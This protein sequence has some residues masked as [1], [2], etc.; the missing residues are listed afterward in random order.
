MKKALIVSVLLSSVAALGFSQTAFA[1]RNTATWV[2]AV[3]G[4]RN[5]GND[6]EYVITVTGN[7]NVPSSTENTFGSVTGITITIEG[8]GTLSLSGNGDILNIGNGQTIIARNITLRGRSTANPYSVV[9]VIGGTFHMEGK[10]SVTGN[11]GAG[12]VWVDQAGTFTMKDNASV[13]GNSRSSSEGG[14][15]VTVNNGTFTMKDRASVSGNT[16]DHGGGVY[17]REG[18]FTMQGG[19]ISGN[20]SSSSSYAR[21][22]GV[23]I[24]TRGIFTMESGTISG[25]TASQGGG[26][27]VSEGT[28]TMEGGTISGN[29]TYPYR[30]SGGGGVYMSSGVF[31][32]KDGLISGNTAIDGGGVF[33]DSTFNTGTFTMEG[34]TISGNTSLSPSGGGGGVYMIGRWG[35]FTMENGT[36]SG[37]TAS[38]GGGVCATYDSSYRQS[39]TFT[40]KDGTISGNTASNSGGGVYGKLRMQGGAISGNTVSNGGG[41]VYV[42]E[43]FTKTG[44]TIY[45]DDAEQKL[46]NT[47]VS[48]MGHAVYEDRNKRWRNAGAGR[49]MNP[50]SYGFW[51]SEDA[52]ISG[53]GFIGTWKRSN[54]NNT[55]TVTATT[56]KSSSR[57]T[58][59][60]FISASGNSYTLEAN[61]AAKTRMT[62][63]FRLD[64]NNLIVSG[65]S[66]NGENNW[67]GTWRRQ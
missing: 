39:G 5:G 18:T 1:V 38:N 41:G 19:T 53:F 42:N 21:G 20:S 15:G 51:L 16:S 64:G 7:I 4:I 61:T 31:I 12:G 44:G 40:M 11:V 33:V 22:G 32:M 23:C 59:W 28:F 46:K 63:T 13:S 10:A 34:G 43:T 65:D 30:G 56:L 50:D 36:I 6:K 55:L 3:G 60:N 58:V 27:S 14:G 52:V 57:D 37:N 62:L 17:I 25:N 54:F 2:E 45:G 24:T 26:V 47:A 8:D 35:S 67:N 66:G 9:D 29:T 49:T 48:G